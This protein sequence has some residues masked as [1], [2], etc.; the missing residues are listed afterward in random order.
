MSKSKKSASRVVAST[1]SQ[2]PRRA[3]KS[4]PKASQVAKHATKG[5]KHETTTAK[6]AT[7][8]PK[9]ATAGN[10]HHPKTLTAVTST[11]GSVLLKIGKDYAQEVHDLS[12][13]RLE[14]ATVHQLAGSPADFPVGEVYRE[15]TK[16]GTFKHTSLDELET[17][18]TS[19][20]TKSHPEAQE[21]APA[22]SVSLPARYLHAALAIAAKK[23]VRYYLNGIYL[24]T[25]GKE[26]RLVATDGHRLLVISMAN[27]KELPWG[28]AGI[29]LPREQLDRIAKYIGKDEET[30]I[31]VAFGIGHPTA[32]IVEAGGMA[33]FAVTPVEGKFPEYVRVMD[34][35]GN[36]FA[37]QREPSDT[38]CVDSA[39][40][41]SAGMV[42]ALL[43][44][45][46]IFPFVGASSRDACVFTFGNAP[47]ALLYVMPVNAGNVPAITAQ[48]IR[49]IGATG[50]T[51]T[52]AALKAHETRTRQAAKECKS[53]TQREEL[54]KKADGYAAR[55]SEI[56]QALT[57]QIEG[58]KAN[59]TD[60][61][62]SHTEAPAIN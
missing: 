61:P 39:Y 13:A 14:Y 26:L 10:G 19:R 8:D 32:A 53:T 50:M 51:G 58:P 29:I 18:M 42:A 35:A 40:L 25:V 1:P 62:K 24:H 30:L 4:A 36:V 34:G 21:L 43:G 15:G 23:D 37:A 52:L 59:E 48:T 6:N 57:L 20:P 38:T 16:I 45:K 9:N 7:P 56:R 49:I 12:A 2:P 28:E 3:A 44:S 54:I 17:P 22:V 47:G 5:G 27:E 55:A 41:K 33:R 31:D 46:T 11:A 60:L